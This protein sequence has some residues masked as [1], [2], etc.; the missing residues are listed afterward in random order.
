MA[1]QSEAARYR[2][3]ALTIASEA[4]RDA[5]HSRRPKPDAC[6]ACVENEEP[7]IRA[8]KGVARDLEVM[9][10][11]G[12]PDAR[13][14]LARHLYLQERTDEWAAREWPMPQHVDQESYLRRADAMLAVIAGKED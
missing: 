8:L 1:N 2:S 6:R 10:A 3:L 14:R 12:G 11:A 9:A 7:A 4:A 13:D 5:A